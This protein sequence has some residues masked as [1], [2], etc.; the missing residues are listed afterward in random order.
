MYKINTHTQHKWWEKLGQMQ[1]L[2]LHDMWFQQDGAIFHT[3]RLTMDLLRDKFDE[4]LIW[5]S[6]QPISYDLTPLDYF[7]WGYD[8]GLQLTLLEDNKE[9]FQYS[10]EY[11]MNTTAVHLEHKKIVGKQTRKQQ[12]Q[13]LICIYT[14]IIGHYHSSAMITA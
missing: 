4:N 11:R 12:T 5:R 9:D 10:C 8:V 7:L 13:S 3:A 6:G 2:D 14:Y 1:E